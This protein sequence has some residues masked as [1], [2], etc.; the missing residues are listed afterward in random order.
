MAG[1]YPAARRACAGRVLVSAARLGRRRWLPAGGELPAGA[2]DLAAAGVADRRRRRRAPRSRPDELALDRAGRDAVH[3]EPGRRV[4]R[5]Q[6][7]V[8]PAAAAR[9]SSSAEQVGAP[10][11]VVDV[12]D[13]RVLDATPGGRS[14][15]RSASAASSTSAT[16]QR[17][18]TGT[19][20]SRSSSSGACRR[21]RERDRHALVGELVDRR[22]Q[23]DGR[24]GDA[25]RATCP[26]PSGAGSVS[27]RTAPITR[28]VVGERLAHAHEHDVAH[29]ASGPPGDLAARER[30]GAGDDLL[31]DLGGRQVAGQ[32]GLAGRAERAVHAAAGLADET[33][34]VTRSGVAHEHRLDERAVEAAATASCGSCRRRSSASLDRRSSSGGSSA[35]DELRRAASA[36]RSVIV[37]GVVGEPAEVVPRELLGAE[38]RLAQLDHDRRAARPA[39]GR[40]GAA[41]AWPRRGAAKVS[42]PGRSGPGTIGRAA[43]QRTTSDA[44]AHDDRRRD[45][46]SESSR[47]IRPPWPGSSVPMSLIPRSRLIIDSPRSPSVAA[48]T[49]AQAEQHALPPVPRRAATAR[50]TAPPT[51]AG[52]DRAGEALPRLLRADRRRHRVLAERARRP[53]SRRCRCTTAISDEDARSARRRRRAARA[54]APRSRRGTAT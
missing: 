7:D 3:F 5:D 38:R 10:G 29:P 33:H 26:R 22:H 52:D 51:H 43:G 28:V 34:I 37:V 25:A 6:V 39:S 21:Q 44:A 53:R 18:L 4:Q 23:A 11:L 54:S 40:R 36:G 12:A 32:P 1:A 48:T 24:D 46:S 31:D 9:L 49:T 30:A 17:V 8:H 47:S 20:S 42:S 16:F 2:V 27:R 45:D 35:V 41:A 13:Q 50:S 15:R 19:S 14:R